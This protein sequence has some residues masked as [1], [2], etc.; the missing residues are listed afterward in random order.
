M[1]DGTVPPAVEEIGHLGERAVEFK[2]AA[3]CPRLAAISPRP[4]SRSRGRGMAGRKGPAAA[5]PHLAATSS[6]AWTGEMASVGGRGPA[7][8]YGKLEGRLAPP[9]LA[10]VGDHRRRPVLAG[11][12]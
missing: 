5:S 6:R 4:A 11:A 1:L 2:P 12:G 10:A 7:S 8:S 3:A 9:V